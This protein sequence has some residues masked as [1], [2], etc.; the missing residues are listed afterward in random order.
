VEG[1]TSWVILA[2]ETDHTDTVR[3]TL[4]IALGPRFETVPWYSQADFY[5]KTVT[6]FSRQIGV[7]KW[8]IGLIV[9]LSIANTLSMAVLE[10]TTEI[11]TLMALGRRRSDIL[12]LFILEG[13]LLGC[14]GGVAGLSIGWLL[15]QVVSAIGIPMPPPPGMAHGYIGEVLITRELAFDAVFLACFTAFIAS[16]LPAW[17]ASRMAIVDALRHQR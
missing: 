6:L 1:S 17:N 15:A 3:N 12:R 2:D 4:S 14:F 10:R 7:V 5:N 9:I 11:G 8:L 13:A 16:L